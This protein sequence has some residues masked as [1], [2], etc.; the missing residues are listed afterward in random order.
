MALLASRAALLSVTLLFMLVT[1]A[2]PCLGGAPSRPQV[3]GGEEAAKAAPANVND[4]SGSDADHAFLVGSGGAVYR[5]NDG[6]ATWIPQDSGT[7]EEL[8]AVSVPPAWEASG[9]AP[10]AGVAWACGRRGTV[11][12][13]TDGGATWERLEA[14]TARDVHDIS[15]PDADTAWAVA[16]GPDEKPLVLR[17][18]D[19]GATW[20]HLDPGNLNPLRCI[21][22][23]DRDTALAAGENGTALLTTDGGATWALQDTGTADHLVS[24]SMA[25]DGNT[26]FLYAVGDAGMLVKAAW[27]GEGAAQE[28]EG[29]AGASEGA[30]ETSEGAAQASEEAAGTS[31]GSAHER[32]SLLAWSAV[33]TG[34]RSTPCA[35]CALDAA[36][37]WVAGSGG[38]LRRTTDGGA[39]WEQRDT[40]RGEDILALFAPDR[41]NLWAAGANG[42]VLRSYDGGATWVPQYVGDGR[43][44]LDVHA[45]DANTAW[46][47]GEGGAAL[48]TVDGGFTW[49]PAYP[50]T[51]KDLYGVAAADAANAWL[52]GKDGVILRTRDGGRSWEEQPSRTAYDLR[53][54]SCVDAS[55]AWAVGRRGVIVRT[56]DEGYTWYRQDR[57]EGPDLLSVCAVD[58]SVAWAVGREGTALRTTDGGETWQGLETGTD[59]DLLSVCA[60]DASVAWAV[61][62]EGTALRTTDGG[63]TWEEL[64]TG[65]PAG[66]HLTAVSASD[67]DHAWVCGEG[68]FLAR[69]TDGGATWERLETGTARDL[70]GVTSPGGDTAWAVGWRGTILHYRSTPR[71]DA[72]GP[73][74]AEAGG[75]VTL[76]G[77]AFGAGGE[78]SS[79]SFGKAK[80][81]D[82]RAW[83]DRLIKVAI[84]PA[85]G[86]RE[87]VSVTTPLGTSASRPL[88][89]LPRLRGVSPRYCFAGGHLTLA[90]A[91]FGEE[92]GDSYVTM[93]KARVG[94][95]VYWSNNYVK[96]KVPGGLPSQVE[97][98]VTTPSGTSNALRVSVVP[99]P[100]PPGAA[101]RPR[102][103]FLDPPSALRGAEVRILGS[104][105]GAERGSSYVSFGDARAEEY[106]SWGDGVVVARVPAGAKGPLKVRVT[107]P[108]GTSNAVDFTALVLPSIQSLSPSSGPQGTLV[109]IRGE[110]FGP[111]EGPRNYVSFGDVKP[112]VYEYWS[113]GRVVVKVPSGIAVGTTV[114]VTV[115][116]PLGTSAPAAFYLR[117]PHLRGVTA[118]GGTAYACGER[119]TALRSSDGGASWEGLET[120]TTAWLHGISA[121]SPTLAWAVGEGGVIL[122]T[123]D[124][125]AT[126]VPQVSGTGG[127]LHAVAAVDA[128][129]AWAVGE[130]GVILRTDDGGATWTPQASGTGATLR[131][132]CAVSGSVAWAVGSG[133]VILRTADGGATW[134]PQNSRTTAALYGV[135]AVDA[136]VAWAVGEG[137]VILR[138]DDGGATWTTQAS[139][140][141]AT[142][143][144]V[145]AANPFQAWAVGSGGVILRTADGGA[146]WTPAGSAPA[147]LHGV[148]AVGACA[149]AVG[150]NGTT[151]TLP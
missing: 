51:A 62:R 130:G 118:A 21:A 65:A 92:Q 88:V 106:L 148:T 34:A 98:T 22:A 26:A 132:V 48:V 74:T 135:S 145:A 45:P 84:P 66:A 14:G 104:G 5:T 127:T 83:G 49:T 10:P 89:I 57:E 23:L 73:A 126:W 2:L 95:Y 105:F 3:G 140:T 28:G 44:L 122:K 99:G 27:G 7:G 63:A 35:V 113:E 125:G 32:P 69:T 86:T 138:T 64:D 137:G 11:L 133:G 17:T 39:T 72:L 46:A 15:S 4:I 111:H 25:G 50:G 79:V 30:T 90:G 141:G 60:V 80:A 53:D 149:L 77:L 136:S 6:G 120:G 19:G 13:T 76:V 123:N 94:E 129:T 29:A 61:G 134:T 100:Q 146:T 58:A 67:P 43:T 9:N 114:A 55:V 131:S 115:T 128:S 52:A 139:G 91:S 143:R 41:E 112:S 37:A 71:L 93:G 36:C 85:A 82:Y 142:L 81:V 75:V 108:A 12:R 116:T 31:G 20:E 121:S 147:D 96:F 33:N 47:A 151:K 124:G 1:C 78:G 107:T 8:L 68:G 109:E 103:D 87:E 144:A 16:G 38:F 42:L 101:A 70:H 110:G 102:V 24:L 150:D 117:R 119:G 40:G 54:V 56:F 59:R 18:T 97:V